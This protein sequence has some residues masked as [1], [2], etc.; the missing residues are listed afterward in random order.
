MS[1]AVIVSSFLALFLA[2][3]GDKT[4]FVAMALAR[5]Y[6][7]WPV[8]AGVLAAFLVLNLLA[9]LLGEVL[10]RWVPEQLVLAVAGTLFL[11]FG[12]RFLREA[13]EPEEEGAALNEGRSAFIASFS[14]IF[15]AELGDKTQLVVI[16]LSAGTGEAWSVF[17]GGTAALWAVSLIGI[18]VGA[19]VLRHVPKRWLHYAAAG[20]FLAFGLLAFAKIAVA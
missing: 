2:E 20:L 9:V 17:L 3:L 11:Y 1:T 12:Y 8:V 7:L 14:L 6:R 10:Y 13:Q 15:L 5:R 19:T 4:Q 18:L 16:S